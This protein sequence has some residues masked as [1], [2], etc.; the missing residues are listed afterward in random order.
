MGSAATADRVIMDAVMTVLANQKLFFLD[1]VTTQTSQAQAAALAHG[2][3]Y[4]ARDLF[5]D[6]NPSQEAVTTALKSM[7]QIALR[8]GVAIAIGHPRPATIAALHQWLASYDRQRFEIVPLS[9]L[10][11]SAVAQPDH[12]SVP[13]NAD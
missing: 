8:K 12:M 10:F 11:I 4:R 6:H 3:P 1:S 2:V 13:A 7:E 9:T 5:L